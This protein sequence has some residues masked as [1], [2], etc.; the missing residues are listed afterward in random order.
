METVVSSNQELF[1]RVEKALESIRPYLKSDGGDVKLLELTPDN[2][3]KLELLGNC[4]SCAMSAMTLRAGVEEAIR[5]MA[6]EV[7]A[8]IAVNN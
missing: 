7:K 1:D 8:V 6:P 2:D 5:K 3:V 4:S